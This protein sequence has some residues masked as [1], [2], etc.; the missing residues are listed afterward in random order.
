VDV[1]NQSS[2]PPTSYENRNRQFRGIAPNVQLALLRVVFVSDVINAMNWLKIYAKIYNITVV[3]ISLN[4]EN[5]EAILV[6]DELV[7]TGIVVVVS[8]GNMGPGL[9]F[10]GGYSS[11]PAGADYVITVGAT[12]RN[13]SITHYSSQGGASYTSR[14]IKPDVV[15]PGGERTNRYDINT[16]L[17]VADNN[18]NEFISE[19]QNGTVTFIPD[20]IGNDTTFFLGTS[21]ATPIVAGLALLI[22]QN[23][24]GLDTW[25]YS[26]EM[27][28]KVKNIILATAT[29]TAPNFRIDSSRYSPTLERGGK[30]IQEGY[31]MINPLAALQSIVNSYQLNITL[32]QELFSP[33]ET[34]SNLYENSINPYILAFNYTLSRENFISL[35][36]N[37]TGNLDAD[38]YIYAPISNSYGEP[39]ILAK[40]INSL[41][42]G[43]ELITNFANLNYTNIL[44]TVKGICGAGNV[45]LKITSFLDPTPPQSVIIT[46]PSDFFITGSQFSMNVLAKDYE[47]GI[48]SIQLLCQKVLSDGSSESS[49]W[50][51]IRTQ[52]FNFTTTWNFT[53]IADGWYD[54]YVIVFDGANN[55]LSSSVKRI[56][57]DTHSPILINILFPRNFSSVSDIVTFRIEASDNFTG[58]DLVQIYS[59]LEFVAP[60]ESRGIL[61]I[62]AT[63]EYPTEMIQNFVISYPTYDL[64]DG[65]RTF[66]VKV[67]DFA[68]NSAISHPI[69]LNVYNYWFHILGF[70]GFIVFAIIGIYAMNNLAKKILLKVDLFQLLDKLRALP[71]I[72]QKRINNA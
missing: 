6:A 55:S 47:T 10:A 54:I 8:A 13:N 24:G 64:I 22:I 19:A 40:S 11:A 25:D 17:I 33:N 7:K 49:L 35:E 65:T 38:L 20:Q 68:G 58:I 4:V 29:E 36:L 3:S 56:A 32:S 71:E 62:N 31:G 69:S 72:L 70:G 63:N 59:D 57:I 15:A 21:F 37:I 23:L 51:P 18:G 2:Q 46:S 5:I 28:Q 52:R 26:L 45:T 42:N 66:Y 34:L 53:G 9:N 67:T 43:S 41:I 30:D 1:I 27:V 16:P 39:V 14:T 50:I 44:I 60:V 12:G 48:Y 61:K